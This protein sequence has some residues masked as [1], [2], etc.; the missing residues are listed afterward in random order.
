MPALLDAPPKTQAPP[1][2]PPA[3]DLEAWAARLGGIPTWRIVTDPA[4]G[5][6]TEADWARVKRHGKLCELIDGTL[7]EKAVSAFASTV[8]SELIFLLVLFLREN[9]GADGRRLG[10]PFGEQGFFRLPIART[11]PPRLRA[12]DVSY[13]SRGRFPGGRFPRTGYPTL[14]PDF[15]TEVLTENNTDAEITEK[16]RNL[17]AAGTRVAWVIDPLARTG[18]VYRNPDRPE[19]ATDTLDAAPALPGFTVDLPALLAAVDEAA[20]ED[21]ED[22]PA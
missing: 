19:P 13:V 12:P 17:F 15:V 5:T 10:L 7:V 9:P 4:P 22:A 6:A 21:E 8:G 18:R 2:A 11:L 20:G 16:L 3:P 14:A 1:P